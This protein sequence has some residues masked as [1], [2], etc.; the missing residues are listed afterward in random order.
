MLHFN[1]H[2]FTFGV[3]FEK[4]IGNFIGRAGLMY[5][6]YDD[7]QPE[8]E[9]GY[10]LLK[11]HWGKGYGTELAKGI[12]DWGFKH[13]N[14]E[15]LIAIIDPQNEKSRQGYK[16]KNLCMPGGTIMYLISGRKQ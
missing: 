2:G 11:S 14:V 7:T 3:V 12:I 4:E 15:K 6:D 13:L 1:K 10:R 16:N 5:L 9:I 8:I